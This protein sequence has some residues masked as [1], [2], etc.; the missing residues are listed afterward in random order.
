MFHSFQVDIWKH[1][2]EKYSE[3]FDQVQG[4]ILDTLRGQIHFKD[5]VYLTDSNKNSHLIRF[6]GIIAISRQFRQHTTELNNVLLQNALHGVTYF[7]AI[8]KIPRNKLTWAE[9][10]QDGFY[11]WYLKEHGETGQTCTQLGS[12][13]RAS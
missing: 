9:T 7:L 4:Y 8:R 5:R 10:S 2:G 3:G 13:R 11:W 6:S 1:K 12:P